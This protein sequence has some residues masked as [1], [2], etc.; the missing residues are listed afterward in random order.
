MTRN[1]VAECIRKVVQVFDV[2]GEPVAPLNM[3]GKTKYTTTFGGLNGMFFAGIVISFT[4]VRI[5]MLID[6]SSP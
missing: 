6:R 4:Y 2:W 1:S 3:Q 5:M